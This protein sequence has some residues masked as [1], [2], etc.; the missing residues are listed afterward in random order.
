MKKLIVFALVIFASIYTHNLSAAVEHP[1]D[2]NLNVEFKPADSALNVVAE[3]SFRDGLSGG[4]KTFYLHNELNVTEILI[5]DRHL[6][7]EQG[8]VEF[9]ENYSLFANKVSFK[10]DKNYT[11]PV[12]RI[13]YSGCFHPATP[14]GASDYMRITEEGVFLRS[15]YYSLWFPVFIGIKEDP[16]AVR[17]SRV[18]FKIPEKYN[19]VFVGDKLREDV[20]D[21]YSSSLWR[22][23]EAHLHDLQV[24]ARPFKVK[25]VS[26][27]SIYYLDDEKS[28]KSADAIA[29]LAEKLLDYNKKHLR[30]TAKVDSLLIVETPKYGDISSL[31]M[32][33]LQEDDF[34]E[35][36][37]SIDPKR[38]LAH[39]LV[40]PFVA[41]P[42]GSDDYFYSFALEGLTV[43]YHLLGLR[44]VNGN[45]EYDKFMRGVERWFLK[46]LKE[47]T[48]GTGRRLPKPRPLMR[49]S[50]DEMGTYKNG[51][52]L[53]GKSKLFFNYLM[54]EMGEEKFMKFTLELTNKASLNEKE[55][56][57]LCERYLPGHKKELK[58]WLYTNDFPEEFKIP[59]EKK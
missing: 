54:R 6:N 36:P 8:K 5:G 16:Y 1:S 34:K 13:K 35:F 2:Y 31:N 55:F 47:A 37:S 33:G 20:R 17:F 29:V 28:R 15:Y 48:E 53:W 50:A 42:V 43:Y 52:V 40:H 49:I 38:T 3:I 57:A 45:E 32:I 4:K 46:N 14:R 39:E 10:L 41:V 11:N 27:I 26:N 30:K 25:K 19:L 18:Q 44:S 56:V 24:T 58:T 7:F 22:V 21:G 9:R 23:P 51:Y 59:A 12:L